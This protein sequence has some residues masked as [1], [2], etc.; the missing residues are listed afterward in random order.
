MQVVAFGWPDDP[1]VEWHVIFLDRPGKRVLDQITVFSDAFTEA[2]SFM[3]THSGQ[4]LFTAE[5][6]V[7]GTGI[8]YSLF[9][10]YAFPSPNSNRDSIHKCKLIFSAHAIGDEVPPIGYSLETVKAH[11]KSVLKR[12]PKGKDLMFVYEIRHQIRFDN[13]DRVIISREGTIH[14]R[15]ADLDE[16]NPADLATHK[17]KAVY[18]IRINANCLIEP[19]L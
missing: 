17:I 7:R 10:V 12:L 6:Q 16:A 2:P 14:L 15:L 5:P 4:I 1:N 13:K 19:T 11:F 18:R 3:E 8:F 9:E